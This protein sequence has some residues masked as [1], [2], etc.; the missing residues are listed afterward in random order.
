MER[1]CSYRVTHAGLTRTGRPDL[2]SI[3]RRLFCYTHCR[4]YLLFTELFFFSFFLFLLA[5]LPRD[6]SLQWHYE[7]LQPLFQRQRNGLRHAWALRL[8][9]GEGSAFWLKV[10]VKKKVQIRRDD[11]FDPRTLWGRKVEILRY[12]QSSNVCSRGGGLFSLSLRTSAL[13]VKFSALTRVPRPI[14]ACFLKWAV[15]SERACGFPW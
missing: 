13:A 6:D 10:A 14:D 2:L 1:A 15:A 11:P 4:C 3:F 9:P 7:E 5:T 12:S 8:R